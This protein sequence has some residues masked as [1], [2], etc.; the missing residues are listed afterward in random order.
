MTKFCY[1]TLANKLD[2]SLSEKRV[3]FYCYCLFSLRLRRPFVESSYGHI[4]SHDSLSTTI[5][6][7]TLVGATPW[8]AEEMLG[9]NLQRVDISAHARTAHN[10]V[11]PPPTHT[12][13]LEGGSVLN[14]PSC[15]PDDPIGQVTE[16]NW[17][18]C[19][20]FLLLSFSSWSLFQFFHRSFQR[21]W[22]EQTGRYVYRDADRQTDRKVNRKTVKQTDMKASRQTR[23]QPGTQNG[24]QKDS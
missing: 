11:P 3:L 12:Q 6:Q 24:R 2:L 16:L 10:G 18:S 8:S 17:T 13:K 5:L 15:P 7:D 1:R 9:G 4:T 22:F 23:R 20:F 14:R 19:F 21:C